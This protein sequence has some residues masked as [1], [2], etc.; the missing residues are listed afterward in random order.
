MNIYLVTL[1]QPISTM[2]GIEW[3]P[4]REIIEAPT[5]IFAVNIALE[6]N[7]KNNCELK[8][9]RLVE[10]VKV[11]SVLKDKYKEC[12]EELEKE[13]NDVFKEQSV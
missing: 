1:I 6:K 2:G 7:R 4:V 10:T 3:E 8:D 9:V 12:A 13:V 5:P 11:P